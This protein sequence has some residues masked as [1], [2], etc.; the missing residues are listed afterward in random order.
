MKFNPTL[1][2]A[3][4]MLVERAERNSLSNQCR[5]GNFAEFNAI[6]K[7]YKT[8]VAVKKAYWKGFDKTRKIALA[9][10]INPKAFAALS[11]V[12]TFYKTMD[13]LAREIAVYKC[14]LDEFKAYCK[15]GYKKVIKI[16]KQ[17]TRDSAYENQDFRYRKVNSITH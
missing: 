4:P 13:F 14:M 5:L 17:H 9:D 11:D 10:G 7:E 15:A 12:K 3:Y 16:D 1:R 8:M 6:K 2:E